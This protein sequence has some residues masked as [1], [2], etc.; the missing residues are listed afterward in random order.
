[1]QPNDY[2]ALGRYTAAMEQFHA[3]REQRARAAAEAARLLAAA[4]IGGDTYQAIPGQRLQALTLAVLEADAALAALAAIINDLA[5][6][7]GRPRILTLP[8]AK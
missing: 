8:A 7:I 2:E 6:E 3:Q 5:G 4:K 1:M